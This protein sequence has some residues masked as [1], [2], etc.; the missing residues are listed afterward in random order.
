MLSELGSKLAHPHNVGV[1]RMIHFLFTSLVAARVSE[2]P[3]PIPRSHLVPPPA[4]GTQVPGAL[5]A[6]FDALDLSWT[7][8]DLIAASEGLR[9]RVPFYVYEWDD[10]SVAQLADGYARACSSIATKGFKHAGAFF[11][12][13]R[14]HAHAWR[15]PDPVDAALIVV[16]VVSSAYCGHNLT[17]LILD[18]ASASPLWSA[19]HGDHLFVSPGWDEAQPAGG[20]LAETALHPDGN[21]ALWASFEIGMRMSNNGQVVPHLG[22]PYAD[23]SARS[24]QP[25]SAAD[26]SHAQRNVTLLFAGQMHSGREHRGYRTRQCLRERR[27]TLFVDPNMSYVLVDASPKKRKADCLPP[28]GALDWRRVTRAACQGT[29]NADVLLERSEFL[30][31]VRGDTPSSNRMPHA[32]AYGAIPIIVSDSFFRAAAHFQCTVPYAHVAQQIGER[33]A[34][35]DAGKAMRLVLDAWPMSRRRRARELMQHFARDIDWFAP[36]SRV[37]DNLLLEA[38]WLQRQLEPDVLRARNA[39]AKVHVPC[40]FGSQLLVSRGPSSRELHAKLVARVRSHPARS[41]A[42]FA[43]ATAC[44]PAGVG[45]RRGGADDANDFPLDGP[46]GIGGPAGEQD[47][48]RLDARDVPRAGAL[49]HWHEEHER[50]AR[51]RKAREAAELEKW[52]RPVGNTAT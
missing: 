15:V 45:V 18:R 3:I 25:S 34:K 41:S 28:C 1:V 40:A 21:G 29:F 43:C 6:R 27:D 2:V 47:G 19:R 46:A 52:R 22:V 13:Q 33:Q 35:C 44:N 31:V 11:F 20:D 30:L 12:V 48:C 24:G 26:P 38:A 36:G 16:P 14:L 10:L 50:H 37:V 49:R 5:S 39:S 7:S 32:F 23:R 42:D 9:A 17:R 8:A 51:A 4:P